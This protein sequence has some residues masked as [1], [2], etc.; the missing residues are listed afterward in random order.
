MIVVGTDDVFLATKIAEEA[1]K[2]DRKITFVANDRELEAS[3]REKP[4][5]VLI[6]LG[7]FSLKTASLMKKNGATVIGFLMKGKAEP[8]AEKI[9][10]AV[11]SEHEMEKKI[12]EIISK[13]R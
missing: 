8:E 9:C 7:V 2:K 1:A 4:V 5:L 11:I 13:I 3:A 10:D 12:P 6:E